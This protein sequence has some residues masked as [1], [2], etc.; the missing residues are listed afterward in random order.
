MHS[1]G[2]VGVQTTFHQVRD[3]PQ[4]HTDEECVALFV[5]ITQM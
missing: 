4:A 3:L 2:A 1:E 5:N